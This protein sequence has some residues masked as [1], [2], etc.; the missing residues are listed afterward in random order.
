MPEAV[1]AGQCYHKTIWRKDAA[2]L[3]DERLVKVRVGFR[4]A[5]LLP[6]REIAQ[7][8]RHARVI[9]R[10]RTRIPGPDRRDDPRG[11]C[12]TSRHAHGLVL[13]IAAYYSVKWGHQ[14]AFHENRS[15]PAE[16]IEHDILFR[17]TR[18]QAHRRCDRWS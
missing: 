5:N 11:A 17:G 8:S 4:G 12:I 9:E 10:Q 13:A 18:E 3:L 16:R 1:L 7:D 2:K 15:G 6:K 14:P